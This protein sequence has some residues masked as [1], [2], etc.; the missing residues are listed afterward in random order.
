MR[1]PIL[2]H[3]P[4]SPSS[5]ASYLERKTSATHEKP[6]RMIKE[7]GKGVRLQPRLLVRRGTLRTLAG[8]TRIGSS[9]ISL[10]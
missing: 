6:R 2:R 9:K 3:S 7:E 1:K 4:P 10:K 8:L 5:E